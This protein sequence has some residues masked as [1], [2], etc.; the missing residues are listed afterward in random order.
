MEKFILV[1]EQGTTA[2][3]GDTAHDVACW[4]VSNFLGFTDENTTSTELTMM[5]AP[6]EESI[7][8]DPDGCDKVVLTI[9]DNKQVQVM[10]EIIQKLNSSRVTE[11]GVIVLGDAATGEYI[12]S[13]VT[14]VVVTVQSAA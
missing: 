1:N 5:F 12:S 6:M 13:N 11:D 8:S 2:S 9:T 7:G 4:P 3:I 10:Q 14:G